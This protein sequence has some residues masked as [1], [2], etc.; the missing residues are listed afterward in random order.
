M[1][2]LSASETALLGLIA[3][4]E[5]HPYQ[6]EKTVAERD[7][8]YWSELSM[9]TIYKTLRGLEKRGFAK[10]SLKLTA[11]NQ[12]R[13]IYSITAAGRRALKES[14]LAT[15]SA[16]E[17]LV[18]R[19]DVALYNLDLL[20]KDT[21]VSSL[22]DYI[23]ELENLVKG[24]EELESYMAST[25]TPPHRIALARRPRVMY[26]AELAWAREYRAALPSLLP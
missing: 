13:K 21:A 11:N 12:T 18:W 26:T 24:Y 9:A 5:A 2:T 1:S 22:E 10:L 4:G 15:L 25:N 17:H 8:R 7:M 19:I 3:E 6:I 14:L 20:G 23:T 16:P